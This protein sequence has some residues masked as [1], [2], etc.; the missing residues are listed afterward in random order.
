MMMYAETVAR[1]KWCACM[2]YSPYN[3]HIRFISFLQSWKKMKKNEES[4][5]RERDPAATRNTKISMDVSVSSDG[6]L[7]LMLSPRANSP[8]QA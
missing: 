3:R 5:E 6:A 2:L 4:R 8:S 7:R 1:N